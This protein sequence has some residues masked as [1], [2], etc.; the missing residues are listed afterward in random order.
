MTFRQQIMNIFINT[1]YRPIRCSWCDRRETYWLVI[2]DYKT[3]VIIAS[4]FH[5]VI[6]RTCTVDKLQEGNNDLFQTAVL[7]V[8]SEVCDRSFQRE[9]ITEVA[10]ITVVLEHLQCHP[11]LVWAEVLTPVSEQ[12]WVRKRCVHLTV[13]ALRRSLWGATRRQKMQGVGVTFKEYGKNEPADII[14]VT[15]AVSLAL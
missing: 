1:K 7:P 5:G 9:A 14:R 15:N 10:I 11:S 2:W 8:R 12:R 3:V 13:L 4:I 6:Q